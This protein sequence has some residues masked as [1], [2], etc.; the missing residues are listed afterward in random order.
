VKSLVI[1]ELRAHAPFDELEPEALDYLAQRLRLVYHPRGELIVGPQSGEVDRLRIVKQGAVRGSGGAADVVLGPGEAF[2]LGALVGRRATLYHYRAETDTFCWELEAPRFHELLEKSARFRRFATQHLAALVER[3]HRAL[4]NEAAGSALDHA[5]MLAPLKS[6]L[7]RAPVACTAE[8][9]LGEAARRMHAERVGS[10]VVADAQGLPLG[11]FTTVDLLESMAQDVPLVA[12]IDARMTPRPVTLEEEATLADAALA[13]ARHGFRHVVVTRDGKLAGVVSE[14]DLFALQRLGLRRTAER[15]RAAARLEHL[16]EAARDIRQLARHLLAQGVAAG[17]LTAMVS[18]LN[19]ALTQRVIERAAARHSPG[20][21]WCWLALGSEGRMEQ[22]FVTDQ[23]N[24]LIVEGE[25]A[26]FLPFADQVNRELDACGYPLCKGEI[27]ARNP[28]WCLRPEEWR[29]AFDGWMR[30]TD[31]EALMHAGIFFDF[32]ALAGEAR[33]AGALRDAL[34]AQ[35]RATPAFLR[36][37]AQA[38]LQGARPPLGLLADFS[39][40]ELDLKLA[41]ARPFVDAARVLALAA[42]RGETN[43]AARLQAAGEA[44]AAEAFHYVQTLRLRRESNQVRV[45]ELN[46][47][48]RRV[49]KG[50]FRQAALLQKRLA[51]D[52]GL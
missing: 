3:S 50:A 6:V 49:L 42:G 39:A 31:P 34:L 38:A 7:H 5:S 25:K 18:A 20:G 45:A 28:R 46:D 36:G 10:I 16:V 26:A 15:I 24:A 35:S 1:P 21:A 13:M 11:I 37:M 47:I 22:T 32:R 51:A 30:N 4:R 14:R 33:L 19:D 9:T 48:D 27:M 29:R 40:G 2:P 43:T 44:T 52:Y 23:D 8:T 41:G 12:R 17:A